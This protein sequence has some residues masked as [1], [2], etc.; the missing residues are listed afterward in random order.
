MLMVDTEA[1]SLLDRL[2]SYQPLHQK[3]WVTPAT[4]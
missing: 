4:R 2:A 1:A 3:K